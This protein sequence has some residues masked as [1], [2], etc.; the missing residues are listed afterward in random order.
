MNLTQVSGGFTGSGT[1]EGVTK[2]YSVAIW[3]RFTRLA[4]VLQF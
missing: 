2:R 4:R 3:H 1:A